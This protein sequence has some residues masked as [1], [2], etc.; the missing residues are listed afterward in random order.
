MDERIQAHSPSRSHGYQATIQR[1]ALWTRFW[2]D[3]LMVAPV[4][5]ICGY[6]LGLFV[7]SMADPF[8][9]FSLWDKCLLYTG[10]MTVGAGA[11]A[12]FMTLL[13]LFVMTPAYAI[14]WMW[15]RWV[16]RISRERDAAYG[17]FDEVL[18]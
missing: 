14:E 7:A 18:H 16:R 6:L 3:L 12:V 17:D 9:Q 15:D 13:G 2:R 11:G 1:P 5:A 10:C 8:M 4:G